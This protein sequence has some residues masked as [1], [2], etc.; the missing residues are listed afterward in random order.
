MRVLVTGATGNVGT[1][2]LDSLAADP[3]IESIIGLARRLPRQQ[4]PKTTFVAADVRDPALGR[5]LAGVDVVVHLA[6]LIQPA[7][8]QG[9][10]RAVNVEG[11]RNVFKAVADAGVSRLVYASS[12]GTYSPVSTGAER[13][14]VDETWPHDGIRS[15][16]YSRHKADVEHILDRFEPDHPNI[17][18][19]RLRP[20]LIFSRGAA[21]GIRRL[22]A[23]P[24]LPNRVLRPG[25]IPVLPLP[26]RLVFQAVHS[27]DVAEA[28]RLAV[29]S[30]CSGAF[31]I[32]AEPA[33][34]AHAVARLLRATLVPTSEPLL[35][36]LASV[37]WRAHLQPSPPGWL[38]M[39]LG[40]PLMDTRRAKTELGWAPKRNA[41]ETLLELIEGIHDA[42]GRPTPPLD[43]STGGRLR[44]REFASGIGGWG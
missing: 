2:V 13:V 33:L 20:G 4:W 1:H 39:G 23:G 41:T 7:R 8:D 40:A 10:V 36:A 6:W 44:V 17:D 11:S 43:S 22:F 24:L 9:L 18:V 28:Y 35:R 14:P 42:S 26:E 21:S 30:N 25:R 15:S 5:H 29:T 31:N 34:D 16:F 19:V 37:S 12:V 3:A 27:T 32:A 38:D